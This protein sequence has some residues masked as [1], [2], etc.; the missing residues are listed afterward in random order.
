MI[1]SLNRSNPIQVNW[2]M[3]LFLLVE[4]TFWCE[5]LLSLQFVLNYLQ[6]IEIYLYLIHCIY[7]MH[8]GVNYMNRK[9]HSVIKYIGKN[10]TTT[11]SLGRE[12]P[13]WYSKIK[14]T[15]SILTYIHKNSPT[16]L[17]K[18]VTRNG[19]IHKISYMC[20]GITLP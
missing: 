4:L 9:T 20:T 6:Q 7:I 13:F 18:I 19:K 15:H 10:I 14:F 1:H 3:Y 8:V 2:K 11:V 17:C 16:H 5:F 12:H